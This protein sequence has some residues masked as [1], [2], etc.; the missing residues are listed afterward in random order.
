MSVIRVRVEINN[1]FSDIHV[2][3]ARVR[4]ASVTIMILF[5]LPISTRYL[6]LNAFDENTNR[7]TS[8]RYQQALRRWHIN[9]SLAKYITSDAQYFCTV[10]FF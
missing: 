7:T 4:K 5:I 1:F 8:S 10:L 2:D 6:L 9:T 3:K